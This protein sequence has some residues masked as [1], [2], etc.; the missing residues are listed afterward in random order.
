MKPS[1][2]TPDNKHLILPIMALILEVFPFVFSRLL[3]AT[4]YGALLNILLPVCGFSMGLCALYKGK[5]LI[6][7]GA[8]WMAIVAVAVPLLIVGFIVLLF[9]GAITGIVPLM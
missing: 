3:Y 9:V 5:A 8:W 7:P 2:G 4:A 1:N 6:G